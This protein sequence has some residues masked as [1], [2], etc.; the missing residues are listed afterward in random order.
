LAGQVITGRSLS[1]TATLNEQLADPALFTAVQVTT[2]V[3]TG[4]A[5]GELTTAP[6]AVLQVTVGAGL[7]V[8]VGENETLALHCP[9]ALG[10]T[11]LAGQ[12]MVGAVPAVL[13]L[14]VTENVHWVALP[15]RSVAVQFTGVVPSGNA[16]PEAGVQTT[17]A[18]EQLSAATGTG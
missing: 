12:V 7:P 9:G 8:T 17:V 18:P 15:E 14:T 1:W 4:K 6:E 11:M 5:E 13:E 16:V 10:T 3:P 2:V